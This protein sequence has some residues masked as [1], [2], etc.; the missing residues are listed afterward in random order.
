MSQEVTADQLLTLMSKLVVRL[1]K[2]I[3]LPIRGKTSRPLAN[4]ELFIC[5]E[6]VFIRSDVDDCLIGRG[7]ASLQVLENFLI[8]VLIKHERVCFA[9]DYFADIERAQQTEAFI[10]LTTFREKVLSGE[11]IV[12]WSPEELW[13]TLFLP[14][15]DDLPMTVPVPEVEY[16]LGRH[17]TPGEELRTAWIKF[18]KRLFFHN[19]DRDVPVQGAPSFFRR[20][21]RIR[22]LGFSTLTARAESL[23]VEARSQL[24]LRASTQT[25]LIRHRFPVG[26]MYMKPIRGGE[27]E[28]EFKTR[29]FDTHGPWSGSF[30]LVYIDDKPEVVNAY[31]RSMERQGVKTYLGVHFQGS[32]K[33]TTPLDA[34]AVVLKSYVSKP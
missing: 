7:P 3:E 33:S 11:V 24:D 32:Y 19:M 30:P 12:P 10:R 4:G 34:R 22:G 17:M 8:W 25:E 5:S 26:P 1:S 2:E 18:W 13:D 27:S 14:W 16:S 31:I 9:D 28:L 21:V 6:N 15:P 20:A 29:H 23:P